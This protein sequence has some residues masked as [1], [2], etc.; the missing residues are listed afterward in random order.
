MT[1]DARSSRIRSLW[2]LLI[3]AALAGIGAL[4]I[5]GANWSADQEPVAAPLVLGVAMLVGAATGALALPRVITLTRAM[6]ADRR[7][8]IQIAEAVSKLDADSVRLGGSVDDLQGAV[9]A[10]TH[11]M[12]A[13]HAEY[14][15]QLELRMRAKTDELDHA[16]QHRAIAVRAATPPKRPTR[17]SSLG[18]V[19]GRLSTCLY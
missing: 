2:A 7:R 16:H 17:P 19:N 18:G 1:H 3:V 4:V 15:D 11:A 14:L 13:A 10:S 8:T 5:A 12:A 6:V 9:T